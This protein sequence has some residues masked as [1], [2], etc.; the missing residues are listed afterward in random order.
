MAIEMSYSYFQMLCFSKKGIR[1]HFPNGELCN[2]IPFF[3]ILGY[4][5]VLEGRIEVY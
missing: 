5:E 3:A 1:L 4:K 2:R